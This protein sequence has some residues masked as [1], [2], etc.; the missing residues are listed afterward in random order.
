ME[1]TPT[2]TPSTTTGNQTQELRK[3]IATNPQ[4]VEIKQYPGVVRIDLEFF[5]P[6]GAKAVRK[7]FR[8]VI[9][10]VNRQH[11]PFLL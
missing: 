10:I 3:F 2:S 9:F 8:N 1:T 4:M 7:L 11:S 6:L 5:K